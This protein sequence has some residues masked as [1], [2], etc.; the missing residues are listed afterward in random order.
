MASM[1]IAIKEEAYRFLK[2]IK[3]ENDSFSDAILQ[4]KNRE[5]G[6]M[7]FFGVLRNIDWKKRETHMKALRE[8]FEERL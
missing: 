6:V 1:N 7:R 3:S 4:F 2:S 8:S 5:R